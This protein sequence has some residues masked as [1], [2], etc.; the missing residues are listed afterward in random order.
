MHLKQQHWQKKH[1]SLDHQF[2]SKYARRRHTRGT[3][4]ATNCG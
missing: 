2:D 4:D 3:N 1:Q